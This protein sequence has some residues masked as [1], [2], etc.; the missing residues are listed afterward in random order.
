MSLLEEIGVRPLV[1]AAGT[2]TK[3]GGCRTRPEARAAMDEVAGHFVDVDALQRLI[4]ASL[5]GRIGVEDAA[6]TAGASAGLALAVA[7]AIAGTD[8]QGRRALPGSLPRRE[9]VMLTSHRNPYDHA[10][11]IGGGHIVEAGDVIACSAADVSEKIGPETAALVHFLQGDL[12]DASLPLCE[13][14]SVGNHHGIPVIVDAAAELPPKH[15]LWSI[16]QSGAALVIFSGGKEIGGPPASGLVVGQRQ[17]V[18]RLRFHA[19]PNY[20]IGRVMKPAKEAMAGLFAAV[21]AYLDEDEEQRA[22]GRQRRVIELERLLGERGVTWAVPFRPSQPRVQP[23]DIP[24]LSIPLTSEARAV[25]VQTAALGAPKPVAVDRWR[26]RLILN[27][28]ALE[29]EEVPVVVETLAE[30]LQADDAPEEGR[31]P[32]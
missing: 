32:S 23:V 27:V 26:S 3:Y 4:G 18:E 28:Q 30:L 29:D 10:I 22:H 12:L 21:M 16:A 15:H 14:L 6:I 8:P 25:A 9:V 5:A 7:A 31:P 17:W 13:M 24:R 11:R 20:G 2:F 1:N 19:V